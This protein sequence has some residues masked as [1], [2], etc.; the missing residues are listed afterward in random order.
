MDNDAQQIYARLTVHEFIL[1]VFIAQT[2]AQS[3]KNDA[4]LARSEILNLMKQAYLSSDADPEHI[5]A[6]MA[7]LQDAGVIAERFLEKVALRSDQIREAIFRG[8]D[9]P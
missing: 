3:P 9:Y 4:E 7:M 6:A 2:W 5:D 8:Q 1:E